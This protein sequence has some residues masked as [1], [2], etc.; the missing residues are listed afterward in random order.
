MCP[1]S[2]LSANRLVH[3]ASRCA[4]LYARNWDAAEGR[5]CIANIRI[6][7]TVDKNYKAFFCCA[8]TEGSFTP[9]P[10]RHGTRCHTHTAP[11]GSVWRRT[12]YRAVPD[13]V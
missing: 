8:L 4:V 5:D 6:R 3:V 9:D 12:V 10:A 7:L 11:R 1:R 13:P 2:L